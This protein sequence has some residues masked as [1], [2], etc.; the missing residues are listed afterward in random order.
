M[1]NLSPRSRRAVAT[2]ALAATFVAAAVV[3]GSA[4]ETV[5]L[6]FRA[7]VRADPDAGSHRERGG[8][9]DPSSLDFAAAGPRAHVHLSGRR[10]QARLQPGARVGAT[11]FVQRLPKPGAD[12]AVVAARQLLP[13][14]RDPRHRPARVRLFTSHSGGTQ[15]ALRQRALPHVATVPAGS[16]TWPGARQLGV[17]DGAIRGVAVVPVG[18]AGVNDLDVHPGRACRPAPSSRVVAVDDTVRAR[19]SPAVTSWLLEARDGASEGGRGR[20]RLPVS[21]AA[22]GRE[23]SIECLVLPRAAPA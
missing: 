15:V 14:A 4:A 3:P 20:R 11:V 12:R 16:R 10:Q 6:Y 9:R 5:H 23:N 1:R 17:V 7:H 19:R 13:D 22:L 8:D 2:V 21:V 18:P